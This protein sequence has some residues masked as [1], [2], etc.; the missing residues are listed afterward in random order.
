MTPCC[1]SSDRT[2]CGL[3]PRLVQQRPRLDEPARD[4]L[5]RRGV[6]AVRVRQRGDDDQD[7]VLGQVPPVAES[8][9]AHVADAEPVDE[10]DAGL[11]VVDD[12]RSPRA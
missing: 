9:V 5:G 11:D 10:G 6:A 3:G 7:A 4:Q 8:Y 2:F 1:A 12:A